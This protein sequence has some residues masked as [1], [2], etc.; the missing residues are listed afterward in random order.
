M[1]S[2]LLQYHIGYPCSQMETIF[3]KLNTKESKL[4]SNTE[5]KTSSASTEQTHLIHEG[6]CG[7]AFKK[8]I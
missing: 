6:K 3:L 1:A 2:I 7:D 4:R 5:E 8:R